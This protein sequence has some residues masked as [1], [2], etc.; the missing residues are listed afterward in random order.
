[1]HFPV[2]RVL[3]YLQPYLPINRLLLLLYNT[4]RC[5]CWRT[6][7][8]NSAT[9]QNAFLPAFCKFSA[10]IR[11]CQILPLSVL[12]IT[13]YH[14]GLVYITDNIDLVVYKKNIHKTKTPPA[15]KS[16][17]VQTKTDNTQ[18]NFTLIYFLTIA[19]LIL[20]KV[21][22]Y[23]HNNHVNQVLK[24]QLRNM[25]FNNLTITVK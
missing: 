8:G 13:T 4:Y 9:Q 14:Y 19:V 11:L 2:N 20:G 16:I 18:Y 23:N 6:L 12:L 25:L 7:T 15:I 1:M 17:T 21:A 5:A 3:L 24:L 22:I 10:Q